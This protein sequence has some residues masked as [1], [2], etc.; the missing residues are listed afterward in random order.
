MQFHTPLGP[1]ALRP[2]GIEAPWTFG[3]ADRTRFGELDAL[4]HVNNTAYLRWFENFRIAYMRDYGIATYEGTFPRIV[5]RQTEVEFRRE[6]LLHEDFVVVGRTT[7]F[8]TSSWQMA[9]AVFA[10]GT[11]R[12]TGGAVLVLLDAAGAKRPLS[13]DWRATFATRD[14]AEPA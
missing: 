14:G 7:A 13:D 8:R 12:A 6:M 10:G 11:L 3:M 2:L 1:D 5:L 4:G 9:Y